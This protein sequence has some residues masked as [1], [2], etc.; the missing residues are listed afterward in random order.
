MADAMQAGMAET[1]A[2][3]IPEMGITEETWWERNEPMVLGV[4]FIIL[5]LLV[6]EAI[7]YV[8]TMSK[9]MQMFFTGPSDIGM[10]MYAMVNGDNSMFMNGDIWVA[11]AHSSSAFSLGLGFGIVVGLPLGVA[12]GRSETLNSLFDPFIT[13][14]N[15]TPRLIFLPLVLVWFGIGLWSEVLIV[16]IGAVFPLLINTYAGVKNADKL[17]INVVRSFGA[18]E[19]EINK[20]VVLPNSLPFIVAGLRLAIGRAILGVVVAEF[21]GGAEAGIGVMMVN[22]AGRYNVNV[23][24]AGLV[25][26]MALSLIMTSGVKVL[27]FR[28]TRW[29]PEKV[30]TF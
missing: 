9:G 2:A 16:F 17:L 30:K 11:L 25:I 8:F 19:W 13:A 24:F 18:S 4:G 6:W 7:P 28:L 15:A 5:F 27:E 29:R 14:F 3:E 26:L 22:A 21:F 23:L 10:I 1:P 20:L 12:L